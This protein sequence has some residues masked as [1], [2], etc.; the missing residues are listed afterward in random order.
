MTYH[1]LTVWLWASQVVFVSLIVSFNKWE[2]NNRMY[3]VVL[4]INTAPRRLIVARGAAD[5][6]YC[7]LE[8]TRF[9]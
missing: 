1:L 8:Q 5:K 9:F 2:Q 3:K 7:S 6:F 4:R